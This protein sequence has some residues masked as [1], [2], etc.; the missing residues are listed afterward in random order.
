MLELMIGLSINNSPR[1]HHALQLVY[2]LLR[3]RRE[4]KGL[5]ALRNLGKRGDLAI[6]DADNVLLCHNFL[7]LVLGTTDWMDTHTF[8][9][10]RE[11]IVCQRWRLSWVR[12]GAWT[13]LS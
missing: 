3:I 7:G 5:T 11:I 8:D 4:H 6:R 10:I 9:A 13:T 1:L 2:A 12:V